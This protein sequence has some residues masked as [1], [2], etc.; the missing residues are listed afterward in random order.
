[1]VDL[2]DGVMVM[3]M[4]SFIANVKDKYNSKPAIPLHS[5]HRENAEDFG[6]SNGGLQ[7]LDTTEAK[8]MAISRI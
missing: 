8:S 2:E 6:H 5:L 3:I 7:V 4:E 1:M